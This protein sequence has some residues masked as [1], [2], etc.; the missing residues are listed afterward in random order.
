M[1]SVPRFFMKE[2]T[3]ECPACHGEL[4]TVMYEGIDVET[5]PACGGEWLDSEELGK[6]VKIREE[7]FTEEQRRAIADSTVRTAVVLDDVDHDLLCPKCGGTTDALNYGGDSGIVIDRCTS[8]GGFWL[9]KEE[10][11]KIQALVEA[12]EEEVPEDVS[13]H[14][15]GI[16]EAFA[17]ADRKAE[18]KVSRVPLVGPLLDM[19]VNGIIR[20]MP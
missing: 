12:W 20:L 3:M 6:I 13:K 7:R 11:E 17:K 14:G 18:V 8:C 9:D 5:C 10:L 1:V 15:P 16:H 2:L 19:L 4:S